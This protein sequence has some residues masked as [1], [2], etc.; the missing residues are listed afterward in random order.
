MKAGVERLFLYFTKCKIIK[1]CC[2]LSPFLAL[3]DEIY[4]F[5]FTFCYCL[6][7]RERTIAITIVGRAITHW[8]AIKKRSHKSMYK[9][10]TKLKQRVYERQL[11]LSQSWKSNNFMGS[12]REKN[13]YLRVLDKICQDLLVLMINCLNLLNHVI[14]L[15]LAC[16]CSFTKMVICHEPLCSVDSSKAL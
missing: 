1:M 2:H 7:K 3:K 11:L 13:I 9:T 6:F 10:D 15:H 5:S 4:E 8:R 14:I 12:N 16:S